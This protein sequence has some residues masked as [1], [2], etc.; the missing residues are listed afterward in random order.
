MPFREPMLRSR[1]VASEPPCVRRTQE[2]RGNIVPNITRNSHYVSFP[3]L[4]RWDRGVCWSGQAS[5]RFGNA[6]IYDRT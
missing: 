1:A 6:R 2:V 5:E 4:P 3:Y